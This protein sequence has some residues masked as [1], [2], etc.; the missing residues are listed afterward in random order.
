MVP[1]LLVVPAAIF[2]VKKV[3]KGQVSDAIANGIKE[4]KGQILHTM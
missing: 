4:A 3:V 2:A 1:V